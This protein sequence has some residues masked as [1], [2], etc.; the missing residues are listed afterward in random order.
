VVLVGSVVC[1]ERWDESECCL[2]WIDI[3][4]CVHVWWELE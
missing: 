2:S 1:G 3:A 4:E